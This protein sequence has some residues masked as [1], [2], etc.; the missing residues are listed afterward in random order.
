MEVLFPLAFVAFLVAVVFRIMLRRRGQAPIKS[1]TLGFLNLAGD[2]FLPLIDTDR[3]AALAPIF[4]EVKIGAGYQIPNCDVLFI[5]ANVTPDGSVGLGVNL[6]VRHLAEKAGAAITVVASGNSSENLLAA[7]RQ[8]GP[9]Q[10]NLVWT[11]DRKG[12]AFPRFFV[13]LFTHMKKGRSMPAAWVAI[14]PQVPSRV[15]QDQNLPDMIC[16]LE[17]GQVRFQRAG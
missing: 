11:L 14:S 3:A 15:Q 7:A 8:A 4:S 12:E 5:Y 9:K 16:N 13:E 17:A 2:E 1:P 6:T 10:A